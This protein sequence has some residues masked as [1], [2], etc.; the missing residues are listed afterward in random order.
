MS[1]E[2]ANIVLQKATRHLLLVGYWHQCDYDGLNMQLGKGGG[3]KCDI[4]HLP[5][6][7]TCDEAFPVPCMSSWGVAWTEVSH[8]HLPTS[9]HCTHLQ[10]LEEA[11]ILVMD[12]HARMHA[13]ARALSLSLKCAPIYLT[14]VTHVLQVYGVCY[15]PLRVIYPN[16][17]LKCHL[18]HNLVAFCIFHFCIYIIWF[19]FGN[20]QQKQR[21]ATQNVFHCIVTVAVSI[22]YSST[23]A[24]QASPN[25]G[26]QARC[27]PSY[28]FIRSVDVNKC[29]N[30]F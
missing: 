21:L 30:I 16:R 11:L 24:E 1:K 4:E 8:S 10:L 6:T 29:L 26:L 18:L 7:H 17:P 14:A 13:C 9:D 5:C 22:Y 12:M 3:K 27:G 19:C 28:T 15:A 20:L 25:Y 23:A 2:A